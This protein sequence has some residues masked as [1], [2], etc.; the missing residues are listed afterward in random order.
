MFEVAFYRCYFCNIACIHIF[1]P[2]FESPLF[3]SDSF[4][5]S[6]PSHSHNGQFYILQF[7][8]QIQSDFLPISQWPIVDNPFH[9]N[10]N[11]RDLQ[12]R[13]NAQSQQL[14]LQNVLDD[15]QLPFPFPNYQNQNSFQ[16]DFH[17][18]L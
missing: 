12:L 16:Q 10:T 18:V 8:Y 4:W 2:Q 15:N 17:K 5:N 1:W 7:P 14:L 3:S 6:W 13:K 9:Q 11:D